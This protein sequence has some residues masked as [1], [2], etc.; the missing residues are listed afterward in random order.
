[1]KDTL[2]FDNDNF[3][4]NGF[5]SKYV[6]MHTQQM[7]LGSIGKYDIT[8]FENGNIAMIT[9]PLSLGN[10]DIYKESYYEIDMDY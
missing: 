2:S 8:E 1:M 3:K 5:D 4:Y 6:Q 10:N 9:M 7:Q